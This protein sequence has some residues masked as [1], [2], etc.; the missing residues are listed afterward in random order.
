MEKEDADVAATGDSATVGDG[1]GV[2]DLYLTTLISSVSRLLATMENL[3]DALVNNFR[4]TS[5]EEE[6]IT[7]TQLQTVNQNPTGEFS[8]LGRIVAT[9]EISMHTIKSNVTRLLQPV[10]GC[11]IQTL[12]NNRFVISFNHRLD[13]KQALGGCPWV[14]DK[15]ALIFS[16]IKPDSD[17]TTMEI[18]LM[19]IIIRIHHLP[20]NQRSEEVIAQ[21]GGKLGI[22]LE[23]LNKNQSHFSQLIRIK[24]AIDVSRSIKRGLYLH[25][26]DGNK[27]WVAFTYERLPNLC[28]ICGQLAQ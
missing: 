28:F 8:L 26:T 1:G 7:I 22:L 27:T 15:H 6:G 13:Q 20:M 21:I 14:L 25:S 3:T 10:K 2:V 16:E 11:E 23:V 12:G 18:N 19:P 4:L 9:K 24:V 17:P 5:D